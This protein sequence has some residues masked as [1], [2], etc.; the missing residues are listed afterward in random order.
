IQFFAPGVPQVYYVG[1]LAGENDVENVKKTGEGREINR[2]NFTLAEIEQAVKKS[3]VQRLLRL[4]RFRNEY[5][6]FDGEFMVLDSMDDE[7][8]LSW[9]KE[10]H[11]CTLTID[12]QI[13]RTVIEYRDEAGR[14]VQYKV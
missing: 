13:N 5:P 14:M 10:T 3:V 11:I 1:L 9:L 4:I 12:L 6:A 8:R 7:V 2:H